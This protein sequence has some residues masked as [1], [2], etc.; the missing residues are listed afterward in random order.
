MNWEMIL[1]KI[2]SFS[3][4]KKRPEAVDRRETVYEQASGHDYVEELLESANNQRIQQVF[5]MQLG[6][7]IA[8]R[9][10][11]LAHTELKPSDVI[12]V[13]K[14]LAIF[15]YIVTCPASNRDTQELLEMTKVKRKCSYCLRKFTFYPYDQRC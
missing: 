1:L 15:L 10:W 3:K 2:L 14:K 11:R 12:S 7:F 5:R 13:E 4:S 9:E 6:T 8:P